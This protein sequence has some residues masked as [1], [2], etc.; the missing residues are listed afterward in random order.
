MKYHTLFIS[1]IWKDVAK[2][3]RLLHIRGDALRVKH[4]HTNDIKYKLF[5]QGRTLGTRPVLKVPPITTKVGYICKSVWVGRLFHTLSEPWSGEFSRV[6][7]IFRNSG[8][9][10]IHSIP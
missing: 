10:H 2:I 9:S 5:F 3:C 6:Y 1:K 7:T 8:S 4:A